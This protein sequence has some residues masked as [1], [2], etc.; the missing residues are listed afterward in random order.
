M[1]NSTISVPLLAVALVTASASFGAALACVP[2]GRGQ[3]CTGAQF[4]EH[5]RICRITHCMGGGHFPS[6]ST[7][8]N[9]VFTTKPI[10][11]PSQRPVPL[12]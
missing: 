8:K 2:P 7:E 4:L 3:C 10:R 5:G 6:V 12:L 1:M 11:I 9:C